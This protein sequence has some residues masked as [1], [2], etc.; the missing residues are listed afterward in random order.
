MIPNYKSVH[1]QFKLNGQHYTFA[2]LKEQANSLANESESYK[3]DIGLFLMDWLNDELT[4]TVTTSGSTG[5]PKH[6]EL[7]KQAM[8]NSAFA[9]GDYFQLQPTNT[10]LLC[11]PIT[12]IAGKMMLI[13]AIVLGLHIDLVVPNSNPLKYLNKVYDF[14]A[15]VPMQLENSI[16]GLFKVNTL[17]VGGA[18][19]S[20]ELINKIQKSTSNVYETY[21]MTETIT[22]IAVRK[23][24]H[25][26]S[27]T[28]FDV[29]PNIQISQDERACLVIHAPYLNDKPIITNDI[30]KL[31]SATSFEL[32]G[33]FDNV[34]NSGGIKIHP[35]Q[36]E[37]KLLTF[38]DTEFFIT[39]RDNPTL[40]EE[41]ILVVE[42]EERALSKAIFSSFNK[43]EIPKDI[44]FV[45]AFKRTTSGKI[46]RAVTLAS[47]KK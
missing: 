8:V 3:N 42:G 22:H 16:I 31:H 18:K 29:L 10:A 38:L 12:Y 41:V 17:I 21:G 37:T 26:L 2:T 35:E 25:T 45:N 34:I 40:G 33:R 24:N 11:L 23:L 1:N 47:A 46:N 20:H 13:R 44:L 14:V 15:M 9:T 43:H 5:I 39:S 6:F 32:L 36:L 28:N 7:S 4:L 19:V 27:I 30:V